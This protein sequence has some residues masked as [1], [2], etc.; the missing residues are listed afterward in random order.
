MLLL[1]FK[2]HLDPS[3]KYKVTGLP[4]RSSFNNI[5]KNKQDASLDLTSLCILSTGGSLGAGRINETVAD[6]I[7][8]QVRIC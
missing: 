1:K 8:G 5:T 7:D 6:L 3:L 2:K 4:I